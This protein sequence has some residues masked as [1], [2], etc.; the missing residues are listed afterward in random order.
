MTFKEPTRAQAMT[1]PALQLRLQEEL[2]L[3]ASRT[4]E[5]IQ[6]HA[7]PAM[8]EGRALS[9]AE[10][11]ALLAANLALP[12][13]AVNAADLLAMVQPDE[14]W[15]DEESLE[16]GIRNHADYHAGRPGECGPRC[17]GL[18]PLPAEE[19]QA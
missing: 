15:F 17:P 1:D 6:E 16:E 14:D 19:R 5:L 11:K 8:N 3:A 9:Q 12:R 4:L 18:I 13:P 10:T 7:G 2:D